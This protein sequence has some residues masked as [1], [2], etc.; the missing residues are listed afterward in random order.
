MYWRVIIH[1]QKPLQEPDQGKCDHL[2]R[3]PR[4]KKKN[5]LELINNYS[6]VSEYKVNFYTILASP[7]IKYLSIN[8]TKYIQELYKEN[9]KTLM[10]DIKEKLSGKYSMFMDRKI[11]VKM[12]YPSNLIYSFNVIHT[13]SKY[14]ILR[15]STD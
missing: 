8:L 3:N 12:S 7:K 10:K 13:K 15:I 1:K 11:I 5:F 14:V 2:C 6:N 4:V 9:Y